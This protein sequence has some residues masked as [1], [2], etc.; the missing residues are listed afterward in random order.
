MNTV[1]PTNK[2]LENKNE[3]AIKLNYIRHFICR[4]IKKI[5]LVSKID[6]FELES[7]DEIDY[8]YID[9]EELDFE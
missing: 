5:N 4:N 3:N 1:L 6:D 9:N 2:Y 8:E 7:S